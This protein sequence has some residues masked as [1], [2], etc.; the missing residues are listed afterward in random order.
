MKHAFVSIFCVSLITACGPN[1][2]EQKAAAEKLANDSIA[3]YDSMAK[4]AAEMEAM[5]TMPVD[6]NS[7]VQ[8]DSLESK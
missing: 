8:V 7:V 4:V 6:S 1:A 5:T 3:Q 2:D